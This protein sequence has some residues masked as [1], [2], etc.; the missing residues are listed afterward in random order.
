M[1]QTNVIKDGFGHPKPRWVLHIA[2]RPELDKYQH[3]IAFALTTGEAADIIQQTS[4]HWR[5]LFS[6]MAKISFALFETGCDSWQEYRDT[7]LLTDQGFEMISFETP[8]PQQECYYSIV[9]GYTYAKTQL[10]VESLMPLSACEK[11]LLAEN[12]P[13]AVTPYFDWRQ[14]TNE[15]L[16]HLIKVMNAK[17]PES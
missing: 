4:N 9:A 11:L 10:D 8:D 12:K 2:N 14:L 6:I 5:K 3:N 13:L 16:A 7:K 17:L 1:G 15:V